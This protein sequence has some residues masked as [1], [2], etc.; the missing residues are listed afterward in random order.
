MARAFEM[1]VAL[2][3]ASQFIDSTKVYEEFP[4]LPRT[5]D[6]ISS[7]SSVSSVIVVVELLFAFPEV[8]MN[9]GGAF[10]LS[11]SIFSRLPP[12]TPEP[13]PY[14]VGTYGEG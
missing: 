1:I 6:E 7:V 3:L 10:Q 8:L 5:E 14:S 11:R 4:I 9:S 12:A 2:A 13:P